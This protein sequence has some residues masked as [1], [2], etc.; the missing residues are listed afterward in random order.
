MPELVDRA[1]EALMPLVG[2]PL[3]LFGHSM[4]AILAFELAFRVP[5]AH[6]FVSGRSAPSCWR[7]ERVHL[8]D[9]VGAADPTEYYVTSPPLV[10]RGAVVVGALIADNLR[11][12]AAS[13]VVRAFDAKSG[14][15]RQG[16]AITEERVDA[17]LVAGERV[18]IERL[19]VAAAKIHGVLSAKSQVEH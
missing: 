2:R 9:D 19:L 12:D 4:G 11:R 13:G 3:I 1:A 17:A 16:Q 8:R 10:I 5:T 7:E 6:L 15:S 18:A 14:A